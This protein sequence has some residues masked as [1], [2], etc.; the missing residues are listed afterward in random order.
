MAALQDSLGKSA[1]SE[2]ASFALYWLV[3]TFHCRKLHILVM[4]RLRVVYGGRRVGQVLPSYQN[5]QISALDETADAPQS[6]LFSLLFSLFSCLVLSLLFRLLFSLSLSSLLSFSVFSL[7]L[8][9]SLALSGSLSVCCCVWCLV[10]C[11]VCVV[12]G[13]WCVV[14]GVTHW[15]TPRVYVQN[16]PVCTDTT[17]THVSTCAHGACTHGDVLD[18]HTGGAE[19]GRSS[20]ASCFSSVKPVIFRNFHAHLNRTLCSSLIAMVHVELSRAP[21][22][23]TES[24]HWMLPILSLRIGREQHVHHS[25]NHSLYLMKLLTPVILRE[26]LQGP[27]CLS[28]LSPSILNDFERQYRHEL[29]P[30]FSLT[31]PFSST[32]HH[33]SSPDTFVLLKPLARSRK[34]HTQTHMKVVL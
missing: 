16:L 28:P 32:I 22:R 25:S 1:N 20:S 30:V 3:V 18:G 11:G 24:N 26:T 27:V 2:L 17:R 14:C 34:V 8:W 12:C 10:S 7:A 15:K 19:R 31:L 6:S 4:I 23:F 5:R 13:V 29:P 9:L 33:L 21:E